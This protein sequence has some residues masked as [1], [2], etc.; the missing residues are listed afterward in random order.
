LGEISELIS[1][2]KVRL[3]IISSIELS[4]RDLVD[5]V[6]D[7]FET[8]QAEILDI[9]KNKERRTKGIE[10]ASTNHINNLNLILKPGA[11]FGELVSAHQ[12]PRGRARGRQILARQASPTNQRPQT[13][14]RKE[15]LA[16]R[17]KMV[18]WAIQT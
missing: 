12:S 7:N 14:S 18:S 8:E 9:I 13:L 4:K 15:P 3:N 2:G 1:T 5:N 16:G 11:K 10:E 6:Q 17:H